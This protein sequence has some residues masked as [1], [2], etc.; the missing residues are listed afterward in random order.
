M[1]GSDREK[2]DYDTFTMLDWWEMSIVCC[3]AKVKTHTGAT[4][5]S[6][7]VREA[8]DELY[9]FRLQD[10]E[11]PGKAVRVGNGVAEHCEAMSNVSTP[12]NHHE[13]ILTAA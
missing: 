11:L 13:I 9:W 6:G 8:S 12:R 1:K 2:V 10:K 5:V 4:L 7:P 3:V